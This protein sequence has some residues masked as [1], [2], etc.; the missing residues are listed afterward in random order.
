MIN[1]IQSISGL[2]EKLLQSVLNELGQM[3][4][5]DPLIY[6][7]KSYTYHHILVRKGYAYMYQNFYTNVAKLFSYGKGGG[8]YLYRNFHINRQIFPVQVDTVYHGGLTLISRIV[9]FG[10]RKT[11]KRLLKSLFISNV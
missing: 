3:S 11:Q 4:D 1:E 2:G 7:Q 8:G 10:A 9:A 6:Q 5:F